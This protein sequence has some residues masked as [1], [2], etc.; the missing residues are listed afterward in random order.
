MPSRISKYSVIFQWSSVATVNQSKKSSKALEIC[1]NPIIKNAKFSMSTDW[2]TIPIHNST[3]PQGFCS[4]PVGPP[5]KHHPNLAIFGQQKTMGILCRG[6]K[7][8]GTQ[9][10]INVGLGDADTAGFFGP[11]GWAPSS[12]YVKKTDDRGK[13][14][15]RGDE[16]VID[17]RN[18]K[19]I[20]KNKAPQR[21]L[22]VVRFSVDPKKDS[23]KSTVSWS[24]SL[25]RTCWTPMRL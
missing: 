2:S 25:R 22:R 8:L 10:G 6:D 21:P 18:E 15:K 9:N 1:W 17:K 24:Q 19:N 5:K 23:T 3:Q 12:W 20:Y 4:P 11:R 14:N 16:T 13:S 7:L